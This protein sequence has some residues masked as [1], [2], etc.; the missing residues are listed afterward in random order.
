MFFLGLL[1]LTA[2]GLIFAA[3]DL[4]RNNSNVL[5]DWRDSLFVAMVL[6]CLWTAA[7][8]ETL[9]VLHLPIFWPIFIAWM[10][11]SLLALV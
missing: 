1:P 8:T 11:P 4:R 3:I 10:I 6:V 5:S 9:G 2:L 7:V